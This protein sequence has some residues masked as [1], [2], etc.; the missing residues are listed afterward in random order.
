MLGPLEI[1]TDGDPGETVE[2]AGTRLRVLLVML[3][4]HPG[5][6]VTASQLID[7]LWPA[8]MPAA[9]ANALQALV[10]RLRRALPAAVIE[11]RPAGYQL[12]IDPRSTDIVRFEDLA[13]AG[14]ARLRDDPATAGATLRQALALWRGPALA[15]VADTDF[16]QAAIAR[17]NELRLS[18]LEARA[19]ADLRTGNTASLVAE[20]E[21]LV[22]AHPMRE[23][24]AAR[25]MRA[26]HAAGRR[27]AALEVYE[28]TRKRLV[29][30][31]GVEPSAE[32]AAL[33]LDILR[34]ELPA[35]P[36]PRTP[37]TPRTSETPNGLTSHVN[38]N[39]RAELTGFVGRDAELRQVAELL[40]AH[41]L[42]TLT[43]PGG[44]GKTRL[45]VE[46]ARAELGAMPDGVW[47]IELAPVTD[48][49]DVTSTV[50]STLGLREQ[51][52]AN[53]RR[54]AASW[55]PADEQ[56][57]TLARLLSA[58][59]RQR[60]L[61]VLDNCE[62]LVAA[63]AALADRVLAACP[64]VRIMAT[65][66]EP[67]NITGEALWA[68]GPLTLP[69]DPAATSLSAERAVV[70][71]SASVRLLA[72][73]ARAVVPGFQVTP[74]NAPAVAT[75]CRAL[76][77][78]PLAIELAAA[79][80]RTM[81][82]EQVAARLGD[83]FGLL[84]SGS[85]TAVPRH[86]TLRAVVDWSWDLLDDAE[87]T[88]WRRFSVFTGGATL[89]AAEQVCSGSGVRAGQ[90]LDLLTALADKSLLTVRHDPPRYRMLEIIKA[91]GQERLAEA[92]ESDELRE[93]HARYFTRLAEESQDH[94]LAAEQLDWLRRLADDQDNLHAALRHA[95]AAGDGPAAVRLAAA[96]GWYWYL[97]GMKLEGAEL[98]G[99][100]V[101]VRGVDP[102]EPPD[103]GGESSPPD[104]PGPP[105]DPEHLAVAYTMGALLVGDTP[106]QASAIDW[107]DR[108]A[109]L[110]ARV[111]APA[112][113]VMPL[114]G[115]LA[116]VFGAVDPARGPAPPELFDEAA[117]NPHPWVAALAR[118]LRAHAALNCG[119]NHAQAE[120]DF[121]SGAG[122]LGELGERWGQA[123]AYGGLAMLEGWQGEH[124]A[125]VGH[126]RQARELV[127][128]FGSTEDE[129]QFRLFVA[130]ELWL[131]GEREAARDELSRAVPDAE[132]LG[133]PELRAFAAYT[134]GDLARLDGR[135]G[136]AR[137]A[138]LRAVDLAV[139]P[140]VAQQLRAVAATG[141]GY[142]AGA[143]GDLDAA[144]DWHTQAVALARF[145]ADAPVIAGALAGLADLAVREGDP[146]RAAELLGASFGIRGTTDRSVPDE[147]RVADAARSVLGDTRYGEAYQ[148][149]RE[150]GPGGLVPPDAGGSGGSPPR[151]S[152]VI[153]GA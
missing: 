80:L 37:R 69:P 102:P 118:I 117:S 147:E 74:D 29:D 47:L 108:A 138:L 139:L 109:A 14:R 1:R 87:R 114:V 126:Y 43:G 145:S 100:A 63:A 112:N 26:L 122:I 33:H 143:D 120:A 142:L 92:G 21:G 46:A 79:R 22:I 81:A 144:R 10:S 104:P 152:T 57:D 127:A 76:D 101:S 56:A 90:I 131:A 149:G 148:R 53:T 49:A 107:L 48:P 71:D 121:R 95:V 30:Q 75:I 55:V 42:I 77:G 60:M 61:L 32:L 124:A 19:D 94:L 132:R 59:A 72:Q 7:G 54:T 65:S 153:P 150:G 20:L 140:G 84:T 113:P 134:A 44:A 82:P 28:Q 106:L 50:L 85:R 86:Q 78:M 3:A 12:S 16:G 67:L 52:L 6:L 27:G 31:L 15:E 4:L 36:A 34:D 116:A 25:L 68:V 51:A 125:A 135:P 40:G 146:E 58:L 141:L 11:S 88:L 98:I 130:R 2:V 119:R 123:V 62:H 115:P 99:E 105:G 13:A 97:R 64:Q 17:L 73:R 103:P 35:E 18:T 137:E 91:Y 110:A 66:R 41:R 5:Q 83:R 9:A 133:L 38:T 39:L 23:P 70:Q 151:T 45:A 128:A 8:E 96:L 129:V 89:E 111:P 136:A 93:A 24:L